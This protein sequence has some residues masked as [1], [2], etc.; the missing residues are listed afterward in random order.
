MT[1]ARNGRT[2]VSGSS[3]PSWAPSVLYTF[4][5][6]T[7]SRSSAGSNPKIRP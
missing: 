5:M 4:S 1:S 2:T 3:T 7:S 6:G